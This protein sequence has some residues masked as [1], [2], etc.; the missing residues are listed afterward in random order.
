VRAG[1][2]ATLIVLGTPQSLRPLNRARVIRFAKV[3]YTSAH[4]FFRGLT[5]TE[6]GA[7]AD[8]SFLLRPPATGRSNDRWRRS[9][10]GLA[11]FFLA[12]VPLI[13]CVWVS[14]THFSAAIKSII[15]GG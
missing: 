5:A 14:E 15:G 3:L 6:A 11:R 13:A 12:V 1:P 8:P 2:S 10:A 7:V 9:A 4:A